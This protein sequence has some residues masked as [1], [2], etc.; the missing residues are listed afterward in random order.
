ML[1]NG[2]LTAVGALDREIRETY[3]LVV[4]ASDKGVPQ[5]E[6]RFSCRLRDTVPPRTN[7][8]MTQI[9]QYLDSH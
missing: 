1:Q 3:E 8:F 5:R 2:T 6:V 4:K 9:S 7:M